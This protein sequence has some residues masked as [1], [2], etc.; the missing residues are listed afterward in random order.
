MFVSRKYIAGA[1][2]LAATTLGAGGAQA[3]TVI[4]TL[5]SVGTGDTITLHTTNAQGNSI[6]EQVLAGLETFTRASGAAGGTDTSTLVGGPG[7]FLAFCIEP[8]EDASLGG[9]YTYTVAPLANG[10]NSSIAGGIGALKATQIS[11]LFGKYA[12]TLS[13][14][15]GATQA[16]ALQV[17]IWEIVSEL[18]SNPF[19]VLHGNTYFTTPG[20]ADATDMLNLAQG[21]LNYVSSA[22]GTG[23]LAQGLTALTVNGNQD[24]LVQVVSAAPEPGTWMMM[25]LGFGMVGN[26]MRALRGRGSKLQKQFAFAS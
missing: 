3:T 25:I 18:P 17:A 14:S 12:P 13:T 19:D 4:G 7:G 15:I 21:Y 16:A 8:F 26:A 10:D 9:T 11:E 5:Q 22:N 6:G 1:L 2:L 23:P 20:S 24:M